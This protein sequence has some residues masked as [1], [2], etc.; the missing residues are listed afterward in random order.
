MSSACGCG[1]DIVMEGID[2][3][4]VPWWRDIEILVP[5]TSGLLLVAGFIT[6]LLGHETAEQVL[7]WAS[8]IIGAATF[9]TDALKRLF[10]G[11]IGVALLMTIS[12]VGAVIPGY[13]RDESRT[14]AL[15]NRRFTMA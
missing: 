8:L 11:K 5:L 1:G 6:G 13:V 4:T 12:A 15:D 10:K 3:K 7:Y 9:V 2:V 14:E